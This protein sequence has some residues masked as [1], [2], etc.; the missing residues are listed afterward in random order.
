MMSG[1][2]VGEM[3]GVLRMR[4]WRGSGARMRKRRVRVGGWKTRMGSDGKWK[5]RIGRRR[6][7]ESAEPDPDRRG[8]R[9]L[10]SWE[11]V[12]RWRWW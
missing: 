2:R 8:L 9:G 1:S 3:D 11:V 5:T 12:G 10:R 6:R 4:R 7:D